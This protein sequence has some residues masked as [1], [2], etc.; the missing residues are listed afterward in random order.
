MIPWQLLDRTKVP[1]GGDRVLELYR[2]G[3]EYSIR[4]DG[5][6]NVAW[7]CG[8]N[9]SYSVPAAGTSAQRSA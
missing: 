1:G 2:R 6:G 7:E 9:H 5:A 4:I 3:E 8:A